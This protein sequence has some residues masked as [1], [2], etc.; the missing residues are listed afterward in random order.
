MAMSVE[1]SKEYGYVVLNLVVYAFLN[2]WMSIQV[3]KARKKY[4]I[5]SFFDFSSHFFWAPSIG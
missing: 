1:I 2:M 3:G 5:S 4:E